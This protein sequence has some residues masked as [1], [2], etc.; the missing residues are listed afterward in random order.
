[1][2]IATNQETNDQLIKESP[3]VVWRI[4]TWLVAHYRPYLG[5]VVLAICMT[6][7]ALP[8]LGLGENRVAELERI[9]AGVDLV[10]PGA[11]LVTNGLFTDFLG[12]GTLADGPSFG[13]YTTMPAVFAAF[14]NLYVEIVVNG[15]PL[16]GRQ[17][18]ASS[19]F[20]LNAGSLAGFNEMQFLRSDISDT[21]TGLTL[22]F[23][24]S[25]TLSIQGNVVA[26]DGTD[27]RVSGSPANLRFTGTNLE[28]Q[29]GDNDSDSLVLFSTMYMQPVG[30]PDSD[31]RIFFTNGGVRTGE[32][33]SWDDSDDRFELSD[34][35]AVSGALV[36]G[37]TTIDATQA[38]SRFGTGTPVSAGMNNIGDVLV[39]D[40]LECLSSII[41]S[42]N[43]LMRSNAAE[44]DANIYFREDGSDTG[45]VFRWDNSTDK[46]F[47]S[48]ALEVGGNLTLSDPD[49]VSDIQS[50]CGITIRTEAVTVP[51][52]GGWKLCFQKQYREFWKE[53]DGR[54]SYSRPVIPDIVVEN[55]DQQLQRALSEAR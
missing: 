24:S 2:T 41:A 31:Q 37:S 7:A 26:A 47:M 44:G 19:A 3:H 49:G 15:T 30:A 14:T 8:S 39:T 1:M 21:F 46:F 16:A 43:I 48:D 29:I 42:G 35:L 33:F 52:G 54:G 9:Q 22:T 40:D 27:V 12:G 10:G 20:A 4:A 13:V 34:A 36:V 6:L 11:V 45:E 55:A 38:Y 28:V 51:V 5:W 23:D 53:A 17:R 18:V 25:S 32:S 50:T